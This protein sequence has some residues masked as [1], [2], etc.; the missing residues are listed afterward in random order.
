MVQQQEEEGQKEQ[1]QEEGE[2]QEQEQERQLVR[3]NS[4]RLGPSRQREH[5]LALIGIF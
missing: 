1:Q 2:Q 4:A 3:D 5:A